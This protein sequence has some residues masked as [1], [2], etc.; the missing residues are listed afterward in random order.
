MNENKLPEY[1]RKIAANMFPQITKRS[2]SQWEVEKLLIDVC[3]EGN[4]ALLQKVRE[5]IG[6]DENEPG[7]WS[8]GIYRNHFRKELRTKLDELEKEK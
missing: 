8:E 1:A 3:N 5:I 2:Y 6:E 4:K 7:Y